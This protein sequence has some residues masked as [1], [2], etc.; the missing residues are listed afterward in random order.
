MLAESPWT[1]TGSLEYGQPW[2]VSQRVFLAEE[3][4]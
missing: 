4:H 1:P 3:R 2:V